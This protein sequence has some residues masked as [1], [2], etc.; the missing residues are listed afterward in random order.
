M[1]G[2]QRRNINYQ[3]VTGGIAV[4]ESEA[5]LLPGA[6][7]QPLWKFVGATQLNDDPSIWCVPTAEGL[8]AMCV[9]AGFS[10]AEI[11]SGRPRRERHRLLQ[12]TR[13][14]TVVHATP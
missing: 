4:I 10:E 1:S 6:P 14:R 2:R 13:Y 7:G 5:V 3:Q 12:S 11:V 9:A 8:R